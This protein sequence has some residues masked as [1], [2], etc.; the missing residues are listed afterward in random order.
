MRLSFSRSKDIANDA[1]RVHAK[2]ATVEQEIEQAEAE[3][4]QVSLTAALS[5]VRSARCTARNRS[6]LLPDLRIDQPPRPQ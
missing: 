1:E 3:L 5:D 6:F 4:R 2:L